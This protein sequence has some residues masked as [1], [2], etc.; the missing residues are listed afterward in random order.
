MVHL[1]LNRTKMIVA[2]KVRKFF[3]I[4]LVHTIIIMG[5]N[6]LSRQLLV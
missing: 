1:H 5:L 3:S 6:L 4:D 2:Q